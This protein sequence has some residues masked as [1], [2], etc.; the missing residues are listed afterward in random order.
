MSFSSVLVLVVFYLKQEVALHL[1]GSGESQTVLSV[2][3]P[4]FF[5]LMPPTVRWILN[6][7]VCDECPL[8]STKA[9]ELPSTVMEK[10]EH[11]F[12]Q[13]LQYFDSNYERQLRLNIE[14]MMLL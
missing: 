4:H 11:R 3:K 10:W 2:H 7:W 1:V 9:D 12:P 14:N 6:Y 13:K 5:Q 8:R